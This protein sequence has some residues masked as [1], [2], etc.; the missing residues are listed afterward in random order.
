MKKIT[1]FAF[2]LLILGACASNQSI[3]QSGKIY[4]GMSKNQARSIF[5]GASPGDDP[6]LKTGVKNFYPEKNIEIIETNLPRQIIVE[7]FETFDNSNDC[8]ITQPRIL[9][10]FGQTQI[11]KSFINTF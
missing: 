5:M 3:I 1:F 6:F 4:S 9:S 8:K 7:S 11:L 2:I 10:Q